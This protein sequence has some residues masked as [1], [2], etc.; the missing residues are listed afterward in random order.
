MLCSWVLNEEI[1]D[2]QR[3]RLDDLE[4]AVGIEQGDVQYSAEEDDYIHIN[5]HRSLSKDKVQASFLIFD[6][7]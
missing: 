4:T 2:G 6:C 7:L 1:L 3:R 5:I